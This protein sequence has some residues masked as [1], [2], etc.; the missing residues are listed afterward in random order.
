MGSQ[1]VDSDSQKAVDLDTLAVVATDSQAVEPG[2]QV[3]VDKSAAA[4]K[5]RQ[6]FHPL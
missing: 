4:E 6:S 1:A 3:V 5:H 2:T